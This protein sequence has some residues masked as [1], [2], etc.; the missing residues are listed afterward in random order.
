MEFSLDPAEPACGDG[1]VLF[2]VP[3]DCPAPLVGAAARFA[4]SVNS[5]L[6]CAYVDPAGYLAEWAP[7]RFRDAESLDPPGSDEALFPAADV[8]KGL[9]LCLGTPGAGW[10]FRVLGGAVAPALA[11]L[12]ASTGA[13]L[14]L[15]GGPR[16]GVLAKLQRVVEGT[17]PDELLRIQDRPVLIL[18]AG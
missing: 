9:V 5:H 13:S 3:W 2:G 7:P 6:V 16:P 10:S 18:P 17:V 15:V 1:P 8:R 11:R 4:R 12:A 14:L